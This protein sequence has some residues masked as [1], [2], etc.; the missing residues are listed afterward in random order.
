ML[1][2]LI[3]VFLSVSLLG[4]LFAAIAGFSEVGLA[5]AIT[6]IGLAFSYLIIEEI[7]SVRRIELRSSEVLFR[8]PLHTERRLWTDLEPWEFPLD[9]G[10]WW[11]STRYRKGKL[12]S[13]RAYSLTLE[14]AR[15]FFTYP[16]CPKWRLPP[17]VT[18]GLGLTESRIP[19]T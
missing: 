6:G 15:T 19:S 13:Q 12:F 4:L 7:T 10:L 9:H 8:F 16:M 17:A 11:V 3:A 14:R 18:S 1:V 2:L 5:I